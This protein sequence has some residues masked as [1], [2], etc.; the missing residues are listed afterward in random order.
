MLLDLPISPFSRHI[1]LLPRYQPRGGWW[2]Y[3]KFRP[4]MGHLIRLIRRPHTRK[5]HMP[6]TRLFRSIDK[7]DSLLALFLLA[8]PSIRHQERPID[9][10]Q[11]FEERR[12][13]EQVCLDAFGTFGH[14]RA[15][16]LRVRVTSEE[17]EF[18]SRVGGLSRREDGRGSLAAL[19]ACSAYD[20]D[21]G[22]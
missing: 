11:R 7:R 6:H 14:E 17:T 12:L 21:M 10:F 16:G 3:L 22:G 19:F 20:E 4:E 15:S 13:V 8:R 1:W 9:P 5:H 2:T 18:E